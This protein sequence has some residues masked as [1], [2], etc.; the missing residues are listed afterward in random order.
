MEKGERKPENGEWC[1]LENL[2]LM[3]YKANKNFIYM[4][5][6]LIY[7]LLMVF[8]F[9]CGVDQNKIRDAKNA[10]IQTEKDFEAMA[11]NKG[12]SEAFS[13]MLIPPPA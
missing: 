9:A 13:F 12:L 4:F 1:I 11:K 7:T 3:W 8:C 2:S 6:F 5:R 10:I